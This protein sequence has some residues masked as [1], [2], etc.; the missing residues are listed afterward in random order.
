MGSLKETN[1]KVQE[2]STEILDRTSWWNFLDKIVEFLR[3]KRV[4][5]VRI[6]FGFALG[7]DLEGKPQG[8]DR[9]VQIG[10]LEASIRKG[11]D[12]GTIEW[13]Q[14]SDFVFRPLGADLSFMLC[15]DA[16]MHFASTDS[17]LLTE[18]SRKLSSQGIKVYDDGKLI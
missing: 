9:I 3:S 18:L 15:N 7:R 5:Q 11:L 13:A 1:P 4:E 10:E 2:L 14:A 6:E 16:D 12:E 8:E 17:S